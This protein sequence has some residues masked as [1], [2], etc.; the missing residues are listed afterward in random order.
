MFGSITTQQSCSCCLSR[1]LLV[2]FSQSFSA[3]ITLTLPVF[4]V[5]VRLSQ[6]ISILFNSDHISLQP[7]ISS[8]ASSHRFQSI[9]PLTDSH[10]LRCIWE[11]GDKEGSNT[12]H[13]TLCCRRV[14]KF[15]IATILHCTAPHLHYA[16]ATALRAC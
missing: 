3:A 15:R 14:F 8:V 10:F 7:H 6:Q 16:S 1:P 2:S 9:S 5:F 4:T 13:C 12:Q 11:G